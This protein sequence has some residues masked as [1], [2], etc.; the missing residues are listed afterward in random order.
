MHEVELARHYK[1]CPLRHPPGDEIYRDNETRLAMFEV[2]GS[3]SR[4]YSQNL[5]YLAKFF[6][7]HKTLHYDTEPFLFYILCEFDERGYHLVG[8]FSKEK[9]SESGYNLA[10]ILTLPPY[11]KRGYGTFLISMSYEISKKEMKVG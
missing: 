10:C 2:D 7:D 9:Y 4:F 1:R 3:K 5:C 6:L 8:Y 11:Q